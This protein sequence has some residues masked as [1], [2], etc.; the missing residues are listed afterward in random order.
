MCLCRLEFVVPTA[1]GTTACHSPVFAAQLLHIHGI[2][3]FWNPETTD[4][5]ESLMHVHEMKC[6]HTTPWY[7]IVPESLFCHWQTDRWCVWGICDASPQSALRLAPRD[8][9]TW[10]TGHLSL[11]RTPTSIIQH[12]CGC[13]CACK[14][15]AFPINDHLLLESVDVHLQTGSLQPTW[16]WCGCRKT[17]V[18]ALT[19]FAL[20]SGNNVVILG[21]LLDTIFLSKQLMVIRQL[22][23]GELGV[24]LW[25]H[26]TSES[27][28][29]TNMR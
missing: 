19:V 14:S 2:I 17:V 29:G 5:N 15:C 6:L 7:H 18:C 26:S 23:D 1:T 4:F 20:N 25:P 10:G 16:L 13:F 9:H 3:T 11:L 24:S 12:V 27:S 8:S 21:D 22:I 28:V